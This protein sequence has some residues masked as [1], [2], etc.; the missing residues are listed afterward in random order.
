[1]P[2]LT[3][4][5]AERVMVNL[6]RGFVERG[7]PVDFVLARAEGIYLD[8]LPPEVR[9]VDLGSAQTLR[10]L[11]GLIRYLRRERPHALLSA[12]DHANIVALVARQLAWVPT[13]MVVTI[14]NTLS[15][16]IAQA[17]GWR[18]RLTPTLVRR[19]YPLAGAVI[20]V[21][22]GVADDFSRVTGRRR[23]QIEVV[24]NPVI[25][26]DLEQ[27]GA[28]AVDHPWFA[29]GQPPVILGVGRL[30][31]QKDHATLIRAFAQLRRT[32]PARLAILG[33]GDERP[34]LEKLIRE[35][36]LQD[37]VWLPGH[38]RNPYAY[39]AR[40][41]VFA[42]SSRYEGLPTV[43]IEALA[44][45]TAVVST[46]C[47]HGPAEILARARSGTLVPVGDVGALSQGILAALE[48][49]GQP[50]A[51]LRPFGMSYPAQRYLELLL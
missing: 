37:E 47:P 44:L 4:G 12:L 30:I 36:G 28:E 15:R 5:G 33:E 8:D 22:E 14:H 43:L 31:Y 10:S 21:S 19:I 9:V 51:D 45:G 3:P 50:A 27:M 17:S 26:P 20:A 24:Y 32:R 46:D 49:G 18:D 38:L 13:R 48:A 41:A 42:L 1:M 39:M 11:P 6:A 29:P 25:A 34:A 7:H 35:L 16:E 23:S 2:T 40:S